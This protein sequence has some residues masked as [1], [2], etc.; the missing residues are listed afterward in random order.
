MNKIV[1]PYN[2]DEAIGVLAGALSPKHRAIWLKLPRDS[3]ERIIRIAVEDGV[4]SHKRGDN[5]KL[6]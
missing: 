3:Q 4:I 1:K 6:H 5:E 2:M